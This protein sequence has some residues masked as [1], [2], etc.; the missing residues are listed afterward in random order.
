MTLENERGAI[1]ETYEK[2]QGLHIL[3][4]AREHHPLP[5]AS[6]QSVLR[7]IFQAA[8]IALLNL[9]DLISRA[10]KD[11]EKN[12]I[13]GSAVVK[14]SWACGFHRVMVR[15][16]MMPQQLSL[17][18][19]S[20]MKPLGISESPT[21]GNYELALKHFDESILMHF[22][23][24]DLELE[25]ILRDQSIDSIEFRLIH[26][27]RICNHETTIWEHNLTEVYV[28]GEKLSYDELVGIEYVQNAVYDTVL[29]GDTYLMQFRGLHQ[30]SEILGEEIND[31]LEEVIRNIRINQLEQAIEHMNYINVLTEGILATMPP[32][33]D[34][35][36]TSDYHK[37]RENLGQTSGSHSV[38]LHYYL[39]RDL[40]EQLGK[41]LMRNLIS[42]VDKEYTE[43]LIGEV[44]RQVDCRRFDSTQNFMIHLLFN[45]CLKLR[46]FIFEWREIHLHLPRNELGGCSVKS[47]TGSPD[48]IEQV[49]QMRDIAQDKDP[50]K[51]LAFNRRLSNRRK[52]ES[53]RL[54]VY[55]QAKESLDHQIL[56]AT[57]EV[58]KHEF[59]EIQEQSGLF[60]RKCPFSAPPRRQA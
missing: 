22:G 15:L 17:G 24:G 46:R 5:K 51:Y 38:S 56:A 30:I 23:K 14:M 19:E 6:S 3:K 58:T 10:S 44:V 48:A 53:R 25:C 37:I 39:F 20:P 26:L 59:R 52:E 28:P 33:I 12:G 47:L 7:A 32:M 54:T 18:C 11:V 55:L 60:A 21:L 43:D 36:A 50:M 57:G 41:A 27:A 31:R 35:L 1:A 34:N 8:E 40:Y 4:E 9:A 2:L 13:S 29:R 16:S 49:T 45:E 42:D